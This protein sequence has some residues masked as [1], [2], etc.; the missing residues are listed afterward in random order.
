EFLRD[1]FQGPATIWSHHARSL[2]Y[3]ERGTYVDHRLRE[4]QKSGILCAVHDGNF[5][6]VCDCAVAVPGKHHAD[7]LHAEGFKFRR[8]QRAHASAT[9]TM[10][11]LTHRP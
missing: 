9:E 5:I 11:A 8:A 10:N 4:G 1:S 6:V 7:A 2:G 3:A